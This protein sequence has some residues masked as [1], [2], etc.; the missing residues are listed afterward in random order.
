MVYNG[1]LFKKMI[2]NTCSHSLIVSAKYKQLGYISDFI[3]YKFTL[4]KI[5]VFNTL[6]IIRYVV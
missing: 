2:W 5:K 1:L 4:I 3:H 6:L